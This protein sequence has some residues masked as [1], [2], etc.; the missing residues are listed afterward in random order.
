LNQQV[1]DPVVD[2]TKTGTLIGEYL[3]RSHYTRLVR[4]DAMYFSATTG[5]LVL[6]LLK[7]CLPLDLCQGAYEHLRTVSKAPNNRGT[8]VAGKGA[9]MPRITSDHLLSERLAI[10]KPVMQAAGNPKSDFIG[11]FDYADGCRET[12]LT[13][14]HP[15]ILEGASAFIREVN[16]IFKA[17]LPY[18]HATQWAE[19]QKVPVSLRLA[20]TAFTTTTVNKNLRTTCHRDEGDLREGMGCMATLGTW[21]GYE[22]I[23]PQYGLAVDYQP[24]DLLLGDVHLAH[25][26]GPRGE[27][28]RV[29]TV[30]YCRERMHLCGK[31]A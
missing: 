14:S 13:G 30:L 25:G 4:G 23:I 19:V 18:E 20:D 26:N 31:T 10:P 1:I 28:E 9:M 22:F 17:A 12:E 2:D 5:R 11:F 29:T 8:A 3:N 27:G 21:S 6:M 24:G 16:A 7:Q 15:E